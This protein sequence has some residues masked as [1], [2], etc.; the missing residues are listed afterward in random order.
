MRKVILVFSVAF[1]CFSSP[2]VL[3][4]LCSVLGGGFGLECARWGKP[5]TYVPFGSYVLQTSYCVLHNDPKTNFYNLV[6]LSDLRVP[7]KN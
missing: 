5:T 1:R 3:G 6:N 2:V 4:E 7:A